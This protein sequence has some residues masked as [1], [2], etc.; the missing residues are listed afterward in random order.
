[1]S[2]KSLNISRFLICIRWTM[3]DNWNVWMLKCWESNRFEVINLSLFNIMFTTV[4]VWRGWGDV[5]VWLI[6]ILVL[7]VCCRFGYFVAQM[8]IAVGKQSMTNLQPLTM[9]RTS[10][11]ACKLYIYRKS[12]IFCFVKL[13]PA[14]Y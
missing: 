12:G 6:E 7:V 5:L 9:S 2:W 13:Q 14:H 11:F 3:H 1:M 8:S 4:V 10:K